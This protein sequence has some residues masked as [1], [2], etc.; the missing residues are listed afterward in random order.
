MI[1]RPTA[2][3]NPNQILEVVSYKSTRVGWCVVLIC[4]FWVLI[5]TYK[6]TFIKFGWCVVLMSQVWGLCGKNPH[7]LGTVWCQ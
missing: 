6:S 1:S 3:Y 4:Q 7:D 5:G 2:Q